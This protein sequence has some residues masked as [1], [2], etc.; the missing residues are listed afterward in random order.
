MIWP[1]VV[2]MTY[3]RY[4]ALHLSA[5]ISLLLAFFPAVLYAINT[6]F[7]RRP[8]EGGWNRKPLPPIS[9]LIPARNEEASIVAAIRGVL[10]S[11]GVELE[12]IVMDDGSTDSTAALVLAEAEKDSRIR[13]ESAPSLPDGWNGK[14]H[15]CWELAQK[16]SHEFLCFLDA[17]VRLGTEAIYRMASEL[18]FTQKGRPNRALVSGFPQEQTGSFLES[19]LIPLVH[20]ILLGY[21]PIA[22]ERLTN[23]SAFAVGCGQFLMVR[24]EPY[25]A[26]GGHSSI[27]RTMHDGLR[28]PRL[29]RKDGY[30]TTAYDLSK[31]ATCRMYRGS[32][33]VWRGLS[34]NATE[35][36]AKLFR[37]PIFTILLFVGQI[38]PVPILIFSILIRDSIAFQT[39]FLACLFSFGMRAACAVRFRQS[40]LGV[41]FHPLGVA[42]LLLLQWLAFLRKLLF[43]KATWKGRAY[44]VG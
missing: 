30:R 39:V 27:P 1:P 11:R 41:A 4:I 40:W 24:R 19:L 43:M 14:Q 17:D 15:A 42:V 36:M 16:A 22:G 21:L 29:F 9:V 32:G 28:L 35:G 12:L 33:E 20:F 37:L 38:L 34:K 13:F 31:D 6:Q 18:N 7:F 2:Q 8:G 3:E 44:R 25:F 26:T 23:M 10:T 5:F